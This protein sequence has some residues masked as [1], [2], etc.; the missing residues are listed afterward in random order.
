MPGRTATLVS[1]LALSS[2]AAPSR[3]VHAQAGLLVSVPEEV[4]ARSVAALV[5][6]LQLGGHDPVVVRQPPA[7]PGVVPDPFAHSDAARALV[8]E[9]DGHLIVADRDGPIAETTLGGGLAS[10]HPRVLALAASDLAFRRRPPP[11]AATPPAPAPTAPVDL[12]RV[13]L[14]DASDALSAPLVTT[15][16]RAL[17][18]PITRPASRRTE[19]PPPEADT[20]RT[21]WPDWLRILTEASFGFAGSAVLGVPAALATDAIGNP[22]YQGGWLYGYA[23]LGPI[24]YALGVWLG[25]LAAGGDGNVW[26][27]LLGGLAGGLV[28]GAFLLAGDAVDDDPSDG[29]DPGFTVIGALLLLAGPTTLSILGYELSGQ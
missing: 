17:G 4:P 22:D 12:P 16:S 6:E 19:E 27:T 9:P 3:S 8:V 21:P 29:V 25:G 7:D 2:I 5:V 23:A 18:E 15:P 13:R 11:P 28:A 14:V 1:L 20:P 10:V 24:G 26:W